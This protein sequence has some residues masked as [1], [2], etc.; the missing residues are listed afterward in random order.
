MK[1]ARG[2]PPQE[3]LTNAATPVHK[4]SGK[5]PTAGTAEQYDKCVRGEWAGL[6]LTEPLEH[7]KLFSFK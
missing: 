7:D 1:K 4:F 3:K 5:F 6:E 2:V